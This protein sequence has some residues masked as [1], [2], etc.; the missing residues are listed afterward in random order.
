MEGSTNSESYTHSNQTVFMDYIRIQTEAQC[1]H[2]FSPTMATF[3][4]LTQKPNVRSF[5]D[6][7]KRTKKNYIFFATNQ[8]PPTITSVITVRE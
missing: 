5:F 2:K 8:V 3:F 6:K 7:N 1:V 4:F